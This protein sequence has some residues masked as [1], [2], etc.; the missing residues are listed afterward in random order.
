MIED[1]LIL[2]DGRRLG[3]GVYGN[4]AGIPIFDFH[5]IPGSRR[6]AALIA[7]YM[8]REDLCFIG[9]DRPGYGR[10][11]PRR[12]FQLPDL[13]E[14]VQALA[15]H[16]QIDHFIALGY[17]GGGPF[18]LA[19]AWRI[20]GRISALGI[21]SGVGPT[22]IGSR[23]MHESNRRKFNLA[24][25][26]PWV[27]RGLLSAAFSNLRRNPKKLG[28][29]MRRIWAQMPNPDQQVMQDE[30]FSDGILAVTQDAVHSTVKGWVNEELMMA[31]PWG[32]DLQKVHCPHI[33]LWHGVMDKNV[34]VE[35]GKAVAANLPGCQAFFLEGEGHISL[36]YHHG[37]DIIDTL[38]RVGFP[39]N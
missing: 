11:T 27:A 25:H 5:G 32:F 30:T 13:A 21:V 1:V 19:T 14:D 20:P 26:L 28:I 15:D 38:V 37:R 9:F 34:P 18:A 22:A 10:S 39:I 12:G 31:A 16:L 35:M 33:F 3:Y 29:Q 23:G 36:L 7:Q 2:K 6:E 17:S 8:E 24:Q 4:P